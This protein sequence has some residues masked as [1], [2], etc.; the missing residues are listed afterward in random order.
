MASTPETD[1]ERDVLSSEEP[2][3]ALFHAQWCGFCR[4]F[5]PIFRRAEALR[6]RLVEVDISDYDSPLW[7]SYGI[8]VVPTLILFEGGQVVAR[9]DG[10]YMQGLDDTDMAQV[11]Q[12][13]T[14]N[15]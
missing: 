14:E 6:V 9:A 10:R 4:A 12:A 5:M 7:D 11:L 8:E 1:F 3:I 13:A 15:R 2:V